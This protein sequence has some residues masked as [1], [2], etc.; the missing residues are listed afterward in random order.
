[1]KLDLHNHTT[2][3]DG[4]FTIDEIV[5]LAKKSGLD[6]IAVTDHD[7]IDSWK[8]IDSNV[9][10]IKVIK[11]LELST[12][13]KGDVV[14]V[15]GYYLNDGGD[16]SELEDFLRKTKKDRMLR[17]KKIIKLLRKYDI[18]ITVEEVL[19]DA[20]GAV[21]RPHIAATIIKKYPERGYNKDD[22]FKNY[23]GNDAPCYVE[24]N[25]YETSDGIELLKRNHCLVVLAHPLYIRKFDYKELV[26]FGLDGI[27][28]FYQ[29]RFDTSAEVLKFSLENNLVVTGGSDFH[30]PHVRNTMG[31]V[32]LEG[33]Y[34]EEFL[35]RINFRK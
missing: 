2:Y 20:D 31:E 24:I 16:Y 32:Y 6:G 14:H 29:Y 23:L 26:L 8:E 5:A 28:S 12:Y 11:G 3:S 27:E 10:D 15:L 34:V 13:H 25:N 33:D 4:E 9:Y 17:L 18:N 35:N 30:G 22:L 1:M 7:N 19:K 21:G